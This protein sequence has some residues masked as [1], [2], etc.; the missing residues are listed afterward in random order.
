MEDKYI[1]PFLYNK[2]GYDNK[3]LRCFN[4]CTVHLLLFCTMN[5]KCTIISQIITFL[6]ELERRHHEVLEC[7]Y[8][9]HNHIRQH[10]LFIKKWDT[11]FDPSCRPEA[12][13]SRLEDDLMMGRNM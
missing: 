3:D 10:Y 8:N 6:H 5:N 7:A 13:G 12:I 2:I 1:K 9:E 4:T 11:C